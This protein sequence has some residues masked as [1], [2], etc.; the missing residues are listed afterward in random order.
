MLFSDHHKDRYC[1]F[2]YNPETDSF[3]RGWVRYADGTYEPERNGQNLDAKWRGDEAHWW[4]E[5][6]S[7]DWMPWDHGFG[8]AWNHTQ[9]EEGKPADW[10]HKS[11]AERDAGNVPYFM[12]LT[13]DDHGRIQSRTE[14]IDGRRETWT[15]KYDGNGRLIACIGA[16]GWSQNFEYDNTGC[17]NADY[18]IGRTP[19]L[20]VL[21]YDDGGRL[22]ATGD[23]TY[24]HDDN[25]FRSARTEDGMTTRYHYARDGRLLGVHLPDGVEISYEYDEDG[26]RSLKKVNGDPVTAYDWLDMTRLSGFFDGKKEFTFEY[27]QGAHLPHAM[28]TGTTAYGL[29]YD[30]A[31][32]LK[33]I[34][35]KA[36]DTVKAIQYDPFG[37]VM[38]DSNPDLQL[39]IGFAGGLAD[40]DTGLVRFGNRDYDPETGRWTSPGA[41]GQARKLCLV[42]P[43]NS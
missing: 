10:G 5:R 17:R 35:T 13:T 43:I 18:A 19:F 3:E 33:V 29:Q 42:D 9:G 14:R 16:N 1:Q 39:P 6:K 40:R 24:E 20:R 11:A 36:G 26:L 2:S 12:E 7:A 15:F 27:A 31:G 22:L 28:H 25:G 8:F 30:Q 23:V 34:S 4:H 37:T 41:D 38:W 21:T 32:S